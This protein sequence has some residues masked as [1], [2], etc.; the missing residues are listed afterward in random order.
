MFAVEAP[1]PK[2]GRLGL[3]VFEDETSLL[4]TRSRYDG[5][6]KEIMHCIIVDFTQKQHQDGVP[7]CIL[8]WKHFIEIYVS[9]DK[10]VWE[11]RR[12]P[13]SLHDSGTTNPWMTH[14]GSGIEGGSYQT[15]TG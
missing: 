12:R 8:P 9:C 6:W 3:V 5:W 4:S 2:S 15:I 7:P 10:H 14:A 1:A 13:R 11:K